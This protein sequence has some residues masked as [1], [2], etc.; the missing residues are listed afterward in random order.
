MVL[1]TI[2]PFFSFRALFPWP[3][4]FLAG[5]AETLSKKEIVFARTTPQHKLEIVTRFQVR[6]G[7]GRVSRVV[8]VVGAFVLVCV[9]A[10]YFGGSRVFACVCTCTV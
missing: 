1:L 7:V 10:F 8:C 2:A 3:A 9:C 6:C 4:A 5:R